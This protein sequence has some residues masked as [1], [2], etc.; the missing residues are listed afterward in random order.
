M[1]VLNAAQMREADR[2]TIEEIGI[3]SIV[4]MENAGHQVVSAMESVFED[5]GTQR[6]AVLCGRGNNG[7]DGFVVARTLW[8]QGTEVGVFLLGSVAD[9]RGDAKINLDV[10]GQLGLSVV[11]VPDSGAWELHGPEVIRY[12]LVVDAVFGTGLSKPLTGMLQ[13]VVADL[14]ASPVP[15]ASVD[16]PTGLSAD[17]HQLIGDTI[18]A[19]VTVTLGAPK[20]PLV[21]PPGNA[22]AGNL[23]IA[24]IGIPA[25]VIDGVEGPRLG[26]LTPADVRELVS[27]R[28]VNAHKGDFGRVLVIA[29]SVGKT[30]AACLAGR[31]ALSSGA[32][33]VTVAT[34]RSCVPTVAAG[35][36]EYM[37]LPLSEAAEGIVSADALHE[38]LD[39]PCDV[40][41]V[42]PGLGI[43][44]GPTRLV[45]GLVERAGV[46]VVLD[47]DAL[48]VFADDPARLRGRDGVDLVVTPH[49]GEMA[50]LCGRTV[51]D[52]QADRVGVA[53][54]FA[55]EH[56]IYVVLKGARTI[57][58]T[59]EGVAFV[60]MTGNPGMATGG[61]GD[62]LTGVT[63][64]WLGQLLDTEAACK[65]AVYLHGLAGD[66]AAE[67][68]GEVAL[69]ASDL[70]AALGQAVAE[71]TDAA[72]RD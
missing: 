14:N 49:P 37:T 8:Q 53:R 2:R 45:H 55:A 46:P 20:I 17:S 69:T 34:P 65:V 15:V 31:G 35:A 24:D 56:R 18:E 9:V 62:V 36:V 39:V 51:S 71:T 43:G 5:L 3:P 4:L 27:P 44:A 28:V 23:V 67:T 48:N 29:G 12:D 38:L 26:F 61:T 64:A 59:P 16:L 11:E 42:G 66:L 10:L 72:E 19:T 25:A 30:G 33:L 57:I 13:T 21:L 54:A 1:R 68:H 60:N 41:A 22:S 7:G 70:V 47:A 40:I 50:R 58:V 32:G 52:V 63:A 6:V